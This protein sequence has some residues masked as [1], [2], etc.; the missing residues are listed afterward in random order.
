MKGD[1]ALAGFVLTAEEWHALDPLSRAQLVLAAV[2]CDEPY[3][4]GA[5]GSGPIA[6]PPDDDAP[7]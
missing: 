2:R 5:A 7:K 3:V 6:I 1:I 4:A